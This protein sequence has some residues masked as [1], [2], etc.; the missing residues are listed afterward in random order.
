MNLEAIDA[1][2]RAAFEH[3]LELLIEHPELEI[4]L[5]EERE[6]IDHAIA[7]HERFFH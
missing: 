6:N 5:E 2:A 3:K 1:A 4:D 7:A